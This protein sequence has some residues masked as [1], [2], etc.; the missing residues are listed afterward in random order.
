MK[1]KQLVVALPVNGDC[2]K[3]LRRR[4]SHLSEAKLTKGIHIVSDIPKSVFDLN[5]DVSMS[6]TEKEACM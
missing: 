3:Y 5:F 4:Y 1:L 6:I 2:L